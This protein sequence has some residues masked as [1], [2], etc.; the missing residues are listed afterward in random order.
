ML[1]VIPD[2]IAKKSA[3]LPDDKNRVVAV[4]VGDGIAITNADDISMIKAAGG[5]MPKGKIFGLV[6]LGST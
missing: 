5:I 1:I 2:D 6:E 3:N 4:L